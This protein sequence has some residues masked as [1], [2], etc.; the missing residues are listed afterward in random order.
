MTKEMSPPIRPTY[1]EP[2]PGEVKDA[3]IHFRE[4]Q[5][6][7][8]N[9]FRPLSMDVWVPTAVQNPGIVIWVH[10]GAFLFGDRLHL[11]PTLRENELRDSVLGAG[12]ALATIDYRLSGECTFPAQ[13]HDVKAA[14]RYVRHF[15]SALGVDSDRIGIWG[16]SAGGHLA[17][18][19][20]L[21]ANSDTLEGNVGLTG[22][23]SA[24]SCCID[25][26]GPMDFMKMQTFQ[27]RLSPEELLV[28]ARTEDRPDLLQAASPINFVD[29]S[30][31]PFLVMHG[32]EDSLVP[33]E[34]SH[35]LVERLEQLDRDV[36]LIE[37][38]GADHIFLNYADTSS[39]VSQS[40][41]FLVNHLS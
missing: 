8:I 29:A 21:T 12:L 34:Q 27:D 19:A 3:G 28:G 9:G 26:Y 7:M 25:W 31:P 35:S 13:L 41:G 39:L 6:A 18:F 40:V 1:A 11:P 10:G 32:T 16:E 36:T 33:L 20:A 24:V 5:F 14:I 30:A 38:S 23:S 37:V 17:T 4:L 22:V 2:T 15:S